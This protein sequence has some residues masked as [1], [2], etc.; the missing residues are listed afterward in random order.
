MAERK[1]EDTN[2]RAIKAALD[3]EISAMRDRF[4]ATLETGD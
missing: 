2:V 1:S 4:Y 3:D